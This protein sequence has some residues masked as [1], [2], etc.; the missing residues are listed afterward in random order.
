MLAISGASYSSNSGATFSLIIACIGQH[1]NLQQAASCCHHDALQNT[2]FK[3]VASLC[4]CCRSSGAVPRSRT[5]CVS[6]SQQQGYAY[7]TRRLPELV[8][9]LRT[10]LISL[11][12]S[13]IVGRPA[14]SLQM[15]AWYL[16]CL[17]GDAL[18]PCN[19]T[20]IH[21]DRK[22]GNITSLV[23]SKSG[24]SCVRVCLN[25]VS[26]LRSAVSVSATQER[27]CWQVSIWMV[28]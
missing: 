2:C 26:R 12:T 25:L 6:I 24:M 27:C 21:G 11:I 28:Q 15:K 19:R 8:Q 1:T 20:E 5:S 4:P 16:C 17:C 22:L 10:D 7:M 14:S 9:H 23:R 18:P 13:A 3:R